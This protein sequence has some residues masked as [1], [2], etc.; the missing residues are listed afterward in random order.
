M[1]SRAFAAR[2]RDATDKGPSWQRGL[3]VCAAASLG[4]VVLGSWAYYAQRLAGAAAAGPGPVPA[5]PGVRGGDAEEQAGAAA[6]SAGA[7]GD[8]AR[9]DLS[10]VGVELSQRA[11]R[12]RAQAA[13]KA[14]LL[15]YDS[16]DC[17]GEPLS[18]SVTMDDGPLG[19]SKVY[20][21]CG[22]GERKPTWGS[23]M[24]VGEAP[25]VSW[26][27][28]CDNDR[29]Y[30]GS[31]FQ[32][33]GCVKSYSYPNHR[34]LKFEVQ[35]SVSGRGQQVS[36]RELDLQWELQDHRPLRPA[37]GVAKYRIVFSAESAEYFGYQVWANFYGFLTSKQRSG[38]WT[39][40]ITARRRDDLAEHI[41]G[42]AT[43]QAKRSLYSRR[44]SPINKPDVIAK[45]FDSPDKP[46]EE[47]VVVIDPDNWLLQDLSKY[48]DMVSRGNAVGEPAYY[49]GSTRAQLLWREFCLQNCDV[50]MDL[51]GVP[52]IVAAK[53]LEAIAPLWRYY[54]I[55]VKDKADNDEA[56]KS[57][58]GHL[59]LGW[60]A[61]MFGYNMAS[62]HVGVKHQVVKHIQ[63]RDVDGDHTWT[64]TNKDVAMIHVGRAWLPKNYAPAQQWAHTEGKSFSGFGQQVWCKCNFT[65]S[66]V[67]P[68]PIPPETDFQS[69]KTLEF[70]HM[71][72]KRF[73]PVPV[74]L[75][76]RK[77]ARSHGEYAWSLD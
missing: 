75:E 36:A 16:L 42:L 7:A 12:A 21:M 58:Y 1:T 63:V 43:F 11:A 4:L 71:S 68:W 22:A 74:N 72:N 17:S 30:I 44:Y 60:A 57:K 55:A 65:A 27:D 54:T 6:Q 76:F 8:A 61:E 77:G 66:T 52:Y 5:A 67:Q 13:G 15:L 14:R 35:S 49:H 19:A 3:L 25:E 2:Y 64:G 70:M 34:S 53:D 48:V 20:S 62:A 39:R 40:L 51:V 69:T 73:G 41:P 32:S 28:A 50:D 59:D 23:M 24:L 26:F 18:R 37:S 45:W 56:W 46:R 29:Y 9:P 31:L 38:S 33:E 47:V 10:L